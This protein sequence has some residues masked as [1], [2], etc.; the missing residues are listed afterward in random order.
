MHLLQ[1]RNVETVMKILLTQSPPSSETVAKHHALLQR[2]PRAIGPDDAGPRYEFVAPGEYLPAWRYYH[3]LQLQTIHDMASN[4]SS[5]AGSR[6]S[7]RRSPAPVRTGQQ[8]DHTLTAGR[9]SPQG[10]SAAV[11]KLARVEK[12]GRGRPPGVKNGEGETSEANRLKRERKR[13]RELDAAGAQRQP[14]IAQVVWE[15]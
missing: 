8:N 5:R 11:L 1:N 4:P 2:Y 7:P 14:E 3:E 9:Q 12:R 15:L 13:I 6:H 10:S